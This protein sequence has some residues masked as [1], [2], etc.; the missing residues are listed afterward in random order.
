MTVLRAFSFAV[1]AT[2]CV[3]AGLPAAAQMTAYAAGQGGINA[4]EV[5]IPVR[6]S[7][8]GRCGFATGGAPSGRIEQQDFDLIGFSRDF[9][10]H[11]N[12]NGPARIAVQSLNGGMANAASGPTSP[13][14]SYQ[15]ALSLVADNGTRVSDSC[16]VAALA[17]G[18]NCAF[19]GTASQSTGLRLPGASTRANGS[20]LRV[21]AQP[22][23]NSNLP[24]GRYSDTLSITVSVSP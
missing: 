23:P 6:A 19:A 1:L 7:I 18:G 14:A 8:L 10:I 20:Y 13:K 11:L 17:A 22:V 3:I 24:A 2:C 5:G 4:I 12:C 15:V 21:S 16:N 9:A